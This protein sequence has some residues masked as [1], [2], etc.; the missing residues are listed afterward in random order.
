[1]KAQDLIPG[2]LVFHWLNLLQLFN[3]FKEIKRTESMQE[4]QQQEDDHKGSFAIIKE[5]KALA[6]M[7]YS[8][9]GESLLIID[10][11]EVSDELR[12]QGAGKAL[13]FAAVSYARDSNKKIMPLCPFAKSVFQKEASIRDVLK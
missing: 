11:T 6:E 9:A 8:K 12:G 13:V 5:G 2:L 10:H 1:M 4:I 7:T 3:L